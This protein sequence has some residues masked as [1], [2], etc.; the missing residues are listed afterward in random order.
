MVRKKGLLNGVL[1]ACFRHSSTPFFAPSKPLL[2][3]LFPVSAMSDPSLLFPG[4]A[5]TLRCR[6]AP[7][8]PVV[9]QGL[10]RRKIDLLFRFGKDDSVRCDVAAEVGNDP[11]LKNLSRRDHY[12]GDD[13]QGVLLSKNVLL[14]DGGGG[15]E[16]DHVLHSRK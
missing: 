9:P 14:R 4:F 5:A 6:P 1:N 2:V 16:L 7:N 8:P 3:H 11:L 15:G 13:I 12:S 10:R